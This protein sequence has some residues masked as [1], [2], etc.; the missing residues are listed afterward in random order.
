MVSRPPAR[1]G[2]APARSQPKGRSC[3]VLRHWWDASRAR[4]K[5]GAG[6]CIRDQPSPEGDT[7]DRQLQELD[8]SGRRLLLQLGG[9]LADLRCRV[10]AMAAKGLRE[11]QSAFFGP[12]GHGLGRHVQEVGHLGGIEITRCVGCGLA[13]GLGCLGASL[14][15]GKPDGHVGPGLSERSSGYDCKRPAAAML[16]ATSRLSAG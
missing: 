4:L 9:Q 5:A 1:H 15:C 7:L 11:R 13:A 10:A 14:S 3:L 12:A 2:C 16:L 8:C 6:S